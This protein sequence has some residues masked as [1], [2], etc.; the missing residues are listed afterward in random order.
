MPDPIIEKL[1]HSRF[2]PLQCPLNYYLSGMGDYSTA[3]QQV[4]T[5][6]R[7]QRIFTRS[8]KLM[9]AVSGGCDSMA[10]MDILRR[11][12]FDFQVA[13]V[14]HRLRAQESDDHARFVKNATNTWMLKFHMLQAPLE[15]GE[16]LQDRA[17]Q[18]RYQELFALC[19]QH[20]CSKLVV[21]HHLDDQVETVCLRLLDGAGA[22]GLAAMDY[23]NDFND[24]TIVRP[25]LD[26]RHQQLK[27]HMEFYRLPFAEDSSNLKLDYRRN[28]CRQK[29]LPAL[30][31]LEPSVDRQLA[32]LARHMR[33]VSNYID[34]ETDRCLEQALIKSM[35][36]SHYL[37]LH[38]IVDR[39]SLLQKRLL[40][41]IV[42]RLLQTNTKDGF[43]N[44]SCRLSRQHFDA[45]VAF[46]KSQAGCQELHLPANVFVYRDYDQLEVRLG[47]RSI[48]DQLRLHASVD[49]KQLKKKMDQQIKDGEQTIVISRG[50]CFNNSFKGLQLDANQFNGDLTLRRWLPGD[51]IAVPW[52]GHVLKLKKLFID[53][54]IAR[55]ERHQSVVAVDGQRVVALL[56]GSGKMQSTVVDKAY[57]ARQDTRQVI[58][59]GLR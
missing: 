13:H 36:N 32:K 46:L 10:M 19:R 59:I 52:S 22:A 50:N 31:Q 37:D 49:L 35:K 34:T 21:G 42:G 17:R 57:G 4:E 38:N 5:T 11:L 6:I 25:L 14:N 41:I 2:V 51:R 39:H 9:L 27:Q 28:R 26:C 56:S 55:H 58:Q 43:S 18:V 53:Q 44:A 1:F 40:A 29:L 12:S 20:G 3:C 15:P 23:R 48:V 45:F 30:R 8:D 16:N 33:E 47:P 54:K 7:Q 24:I